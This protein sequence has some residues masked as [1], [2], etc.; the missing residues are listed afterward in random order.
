MIQPSMSKAGALIECA[1]PFNN[2]L[3]P[4]I[5]QNEAMRFGAAAHAIWESG[6]RAGIASKIPAGVIPK[7]AKDFEF[8]EAELRE[9]TLSAYDE[10]LR[11]LGGGN[12]WNV[13]LLP[14]PKGAA[15]VE[16]ALAFDV[17]TGVA[18]IAANVDE[19][20]VYPDVTPDEH[21]G[22]LDF[23]LR[24]GLYGAKRLPERLRR[25]VFVLDHKT[26]LTVD[27]P[28]ESRQL[29]SLA[30]TLATLWK[31]DRAIVALLHAPRGGIPM[32]IADE[33]NEKDLDDHH[34]QLRAA[35]GR[36]G[37]GSLRPNPGCHWCPGITVCPA[38]GASLATLA[39]S[40]GPPGEPLIEEAKNKLKEQNGG[41]A[42]RARLDLST[43]NGIGAA[44]MLV[45]MLRACDEQLSDRIKQWLREQN[46]DGTDRFGVRPDG[47][48]TVLKTVERENLSLAS[49]KRH[50]PLA[51]A[52]K[53]ERL[54]RD[55]GCIE[56]LPREELRAVDDR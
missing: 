36:I 53:M 55:K 34:Q 50:L 45:Q 15:L 40:L 24:L 1:W 4:K 30:L 52:A 5:Q 2:P 17:A 46:E 54:L 12:Y 19:N 51:E 35:F 25:S 18:R 44:H 41:I 23:A 37:D 21:P 42:P 20:H 13:N 8:E 7:I 33:L 9:H 22:T 26:G 56:K 27:P 39:D 32:V 43:P 38:Y 31:A 6:L 16:Q 3:V 47:K 14:A 29:R 28:R 10:L 49:I 11:W 48:L